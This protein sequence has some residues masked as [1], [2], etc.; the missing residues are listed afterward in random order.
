[1]TNAT[2]SDDIPRFI[3]IGDR[4]EDGQALRQWRAK[5][6]VKSLREGM[7]LQ[8]RMSQEAL[9][10]KAQAAE[11]AAPTDGT[12]EPAINPASLAAMATAPVNTKAQ[13]HITRVGIHEAGMAFSIRM[14]NGRQIR[15]TV[16][17]PALVNARDPETGKPKLG[18]L[19]CEIDEQASFGMVTDKTKPDAK[20]QAH[21]DIY[22][23]I[24]HTMAQPGNQHLTA[25][26][27]RLIHY[28]AQEEFKYAVKDHG[29]V[30]PP[31]S[32]RLDNTPLRPH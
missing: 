31:R 5:R 20:P 17:D 19:V 30:E 25:L 24:E 15:N 7:V 3:N 29:A 2:P 21:Q 27:D 6:F 11:P 18:A 12:T 23:A 32:P 14:G 9:A 28:V 8:V 13:P 10:A 26:A 4:P 22:R 16:V 1:M